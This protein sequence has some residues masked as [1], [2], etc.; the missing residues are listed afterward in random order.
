M[1]QGVYAPGQI[2]IPTRGW[3]LFGGENTT[4]IQAQK[5]NPQTMVFESTGPLLF[6]GHF[7][8]GQCLLQVAVVWLVNFKQHTK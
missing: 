6:N 7:D 8:V 2:N 5:I 4:L 3:F 1:V